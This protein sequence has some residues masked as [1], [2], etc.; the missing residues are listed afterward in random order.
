MEAHP[1]ARL[2][3]AKL[4]SAVEDAPPF[5]AADVLGDRLASELDAR[6]V[7]FLIADFSGHALIRLGHAG[8]LT[9]T[10]TQGEETAVRV[11][12]EGTAPGRALSSQAL[13]VEP[14][15]L[16]T[17]VFAPVTN[18]GEAIG[19]LELLLRETPDAQTQA[20]VAIAA[21]ALAYVI[22]ANRRF[23]DLFEWGQRTVPLSLAAE[24]QRR[25]LPASFTCEADQFT[26]AGWLE[27]A[28]NVGGDTFDFSLERGVLHFS[29]TDA[30][31]HEVA[32]A[33]LAT[34]MIGG[35]RNARRAGVGLAEQVGFANDGLLD[36]APDGGFV[37]GQVGRID[38][39]AGTATII[40][41]GH[42]LP[43]RVRGARVDPVELHPDPPFGTVRGHQYRVQ[44][45]PLEPG[46]RLFFFTDGMLERNTT[47]VDVGR[48]VAA[49]A[50]YHPREAV[51]HLMQ[52]IFAA[53]GG[54]L[55]DDATAMCLDWH[56]GPVRNRTSSSGADRR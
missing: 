8:D 50:G 13:T 27:P 53:T 51:Q 42:P 33:L 17:R 12:L 6:E 38:L 37:T 35:L 54:Q 25:L 15:E 48:M 1:P 4:L 30:M 56:G 43:L 28:G 39:R 29:I 23:T 36:G 47:S 22:I 46:D 20:E 45:L 9:A 19:V 41:A 52:A 3:F 5:S 11:P 7:S 49:G 26:L 21:H 18:R 14:D 10:R 55:I 2:E 32:A 40:N 44:H 16:G 31:G 34:L 24:I